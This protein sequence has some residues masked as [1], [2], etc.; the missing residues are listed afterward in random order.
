MLDYSGDDLDIFLGKAEVKLTE[1]G[2][3]LYTQ[4]KYGQVDDSLVDK[5]NLLSVI[6]D[7]IEETT[8]EDEIKVLVSFALDYYNLSAVV[9]SP[10][11]VLPTTIVTNNS[12]GTGEDGVGIDNITL[13]STVG[14]VKTYRVTLTNT[15]YYDIV[16]NDGIV[17]SNG[18]SSYTYIAYASDSSGTGFTTIFNASLDYIAI[19]ASSTVLTPL[20]GDFA[21]LW[22]NYK[23]TQG[24]QGIQGIAGPVNI[25]ITEPATIGAASDSYTYSSKL[26]RTI[27]G[28]VVANLSTTAKTII[29]AINENYT[30]IVANTTAIAGKEALIPKTFLTLSIASGVTSWNFATSVNAKITLT[31]NVTTF[32]VSNPTVGYTYVLFVTQDGT[33]SRTMVLPTGSKVSNGGTGAIVPT[34]AIGTVDIYTCIWDGTNYWWNRGP[35]YN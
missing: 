24:I 12:G 5:I 6:I 2:E 4:L 26:L 22:K 20:V 9:Y 11:N 13:F 27:F 10:F 29:G 3:E 25:D 17:G 19:K 34:P 8:D 33:G 30:A 31:A 18:V 15:T 23:G 7:S 28:N 16:V 21:G 35:N 1:L 14:L 32:T